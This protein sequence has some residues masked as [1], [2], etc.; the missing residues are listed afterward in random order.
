MREN[1]LIWEVGG[2]KKKVTLAWISG[3]FTSLLSASGE[4]H[5]II[6]FNHGKR[7]EVFVLVMLKPEHLFFVCFIIVDL[8]HS[9]NF[10][11]TVEWPSRVCVCVYGLTLTLSPNPNPII[12]IYIL[13]HLP[14]RSKPRDCTQFF[15]LSSC[16]VHYYIPR[17]GMDLRYIVGAR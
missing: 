17:A 1:P 8:Q 7:M 9:F 6:K 4:P 14:S 16:F 12:Y 10:C 3:S 15:V 5:L 13:Y 2:G 11:C